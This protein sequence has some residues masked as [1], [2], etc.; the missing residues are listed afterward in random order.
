[1][2]PTTTAN[3]A[4]LTLTPSYRLTGALALL[5]A[6]VLI[7][8]LLSAGFQFIP[9]PVSFA[10]GWWLLDECERRFADICHLTGRLQ[11]SQQGNICWQGQQWRLQTARIRSNQILLWRLEGITGQIWLPI[12]PDA[13]SLSGYRTLALYSHHHRSISG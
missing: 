3:F 5:Y 8:L 11:I 2:S 6:S 13:C 1:M 7:L 4:D 10:A 9:W 12:C